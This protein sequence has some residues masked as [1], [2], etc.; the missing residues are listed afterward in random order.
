MKFF[1]GLDLGQARDYTAIAILERTSP[2]GEAG[3]PPATYQCGYLYRFPLGTL[4]PAIVAH[5][6]AMMA[7]PQLNGQSTLIADSTGVGRPV[8]DMLRAA[9][10]KPIAASIHGGTAT[11]QAGNFWNVPKRELVSVLQV[12]LQSGR[13]AFGADLPEWAT[14]SKELQNFKAKISAAGH[15]SYGA[16]DDWRDGS[17]DDLVLAVALSAWRAEWHDKQAR[18]QWILSAA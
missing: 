2:P 5:M 18:R 17:H 14:L 10:L 15:D 7:T 12:L 6:A 9:G 3:A 4:Y 16:G 1:A 8:V 13:L 11:T